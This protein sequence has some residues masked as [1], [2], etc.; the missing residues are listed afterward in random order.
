MADGGGGGVVRPLGLYTEL[1]IYPRVGGGNVGGNTFEPN[2][3]AAALT[4]INKIIESSVAGNIAITTNTQIRRTVKFSLITQVSKAYVQFYV[5]GTSGD[6]VHV[7]LFDVTGA[8]TISGDTSAALGAAQGNEIIS[9]EMHANLPTADHVV[10]LRAW[11]ATTTT[12]PVYL[13]GCLL[14]VQY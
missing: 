5:E 3:A 13:V 1:W 12:N 9:A 8:A 11:D 6:T 14:V 2:V 7:E 10:T 4:E